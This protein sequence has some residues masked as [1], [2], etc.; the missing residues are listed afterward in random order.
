MFKAQDDEGD[1][2]FGDE[3]STLA[4]I[5]KISGMD[6]DRLTN[7]VAQNKEKYLGLI[8]ADE[9]EA[10]SFGISGTPG[11]IV[12]TTLIAGADQLA[13]FKAAIDKEL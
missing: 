10:A 8:Q 11:F 13:V 3:A 5:R 6:A 12:G 4:L 7:V 2:G 9:T 1:Q